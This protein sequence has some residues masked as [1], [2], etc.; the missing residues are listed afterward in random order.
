M[1]GKGKN[2]FRR[3]FIKATSLLIIVFLIIFM[4]MF[5]NFKNTLRKQFGESEKQ[6]VEVVANNIDY[7]LNSVENMSNS[8]ISNAELTN[9][10]KTGEKE[11]LVDKLYSFYIS[12]NNIEGIY[13]I[14]P[15]GYLQV[16]AELQD[17]VKSFP[18]SELD[19]TTGEIVWFPTK[20]KQ[21][22]ILSGNMTKRYFSMGRKIIDVYSLKELGF[23][24]IEVD[25][26]VLAGAISDLQ[27]EKSKVVIYDNLGNMIVSSDDDFITADSSKSSYF[28]K[29]IQDDKPNYISYYQ[30]GKKYV[31]IYTSFNYGKWYI[32]KTV[33][34]AVLYS[35]LNKMQLYTLLGGVISLVIMFNAAYIYARKITKPIEIMMYQMKKVEDGNLDVRVES[36]VYNELDDLSDSFNQMVNQIKNLMDDIVAVEHNKNELELEVLHAQINPHF[37]YNTLNTIRWMAKIKGEDSIS[38]ALVALVKLLRVSISFGNN[39]ITLEEEIA[40]IEN[41]LLIQKL[42]FNQLFE[43]HYDIIEEHKL[44][45]IPKLIL[46]PIVENSLIYGIDEAEDR[47]EPIVIRIFTR[48][49]ENHIE[50]VVEDN[51]N[52]IEKEVLDKIFKQEQNINRFSKVGLNNVNQRLKLYLG[53][54]YG[55]K[56]ISTVG[57]GT[58]VIISVP[59]NTL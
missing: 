47:E 10:I 55:L 48:R 37:L 50:I 42:R 40:Y 3:Q 19:D 41:Y 22:K 54:A 23:I 44:L 32:V 11:Q 20:E 43:I 30:D 2:S 34:E 25:E 56:I 59:D 12:N 5:Q 16:G 39:M 15:S 7:I 38:D 14:T 6:S 36:N 58:T 57:V 8:I 27:E 28:N 9:D 24:N 26:S 45:N 18:R 49:E 35:D 51:G 52:G 29:M 21:V 13:V 1:T 53:D 17:G 33:P 4:A 31:A 46:Q